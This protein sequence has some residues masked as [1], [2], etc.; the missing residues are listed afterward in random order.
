ML[1]SGRVFEV[2][3]VVPD[4]DYPSYRH[5]APEGRWDDCLRGAMD[6]AYEDWVRV[7]RGDGYPACTASDG[8]AVLQVLDSLRRI[9]AFPGLDDLVSSGRDASWR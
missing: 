8:Q 7:L 9:G 5:L 4:A 2:S 6:L 3:G 1:D